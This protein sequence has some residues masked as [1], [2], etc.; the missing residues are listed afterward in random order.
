MIYLIQ[1]LATLIGG[2]A[3]FDRVNTIKLFNAESLEVIC[4]F[5]IARLVKLLKGHASRLRR[6][7]KAA[8]IAP[9]T[10]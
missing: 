3:H 4:S 10:S 8:K 5:C 6:E 2:I 9:S 1:F 7:R